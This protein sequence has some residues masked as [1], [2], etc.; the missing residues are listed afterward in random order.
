MKVDRVCLCI[1]R[2]AYC[3]HTTQYTNRKRKTQ[4]R[5]EKMCI[6]SSGTSLCMFVYSIQKEWERQHSQYGEWRV[7]TES[8]KYVL[9]CILFCSTFWKCKISVFGARWLILFLLQRNKHRQI[10]ILNRDCGSLK[11]K[12][13]MIIKVVLTLDSWKVSTKNIADYNHF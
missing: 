6:E 3:V 10:D 5:A 9:F 12:M 1:L 11:F 13:I 8:E 7:T 2:S 4:Q